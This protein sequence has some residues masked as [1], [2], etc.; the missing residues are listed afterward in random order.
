MLPNSE[1]ISTKLSD[2]N[3]AFSK[4]ERLGNLIVP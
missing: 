4:L 2:K 3:I 1:K